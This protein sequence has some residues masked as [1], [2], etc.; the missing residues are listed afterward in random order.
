[1]LLSTIFGALILTGSFPIAISTDSNSSTSGSSQGDSGD[2]FQNAR[3]TFY[4]VGLGACG[5]TNQSSDFIVALNSQQFGSGY[6]GPNCFKEIEIHYNGKSHTAEI[7]DK[8]PGCPYGGLDFSRGLFDYFAS[9]DLGVLTGS[10]S[11]TNGSGASGSNATSSA[12]LGSSTSASDGPS[13][14]AGPD[15]SLSGCS[16]PS[17]T[18]NP[19]ISSTT[20]PEISSSS[21]SP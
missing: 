20:S 2:T 6:P 15:S 12:D 3:F 21:S 7:M 17:S 11:F 1:M 18:T 9:E 5:L 19:V 16:G 10:W 8:C 13:S 4:D 14:T